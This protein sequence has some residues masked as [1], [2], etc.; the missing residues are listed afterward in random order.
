[1]DA[2]HWALVV[3]ATVV[4]AGW[5]LIGARASDAYGRARRD[6]MPDSGHGRW[7]DHAYDDGAD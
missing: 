1:M 3:I 2:F 6:E 7:L 4:M 5:V